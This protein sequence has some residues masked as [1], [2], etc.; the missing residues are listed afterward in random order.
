MFGL[1]CIYIETGS[2]TILHSNAV[3]VKFINLY[4]FD[5]QY[6]VTTYG[7]SLHNDKL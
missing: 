5:I 1:F 6:F 3:N 4:I 2:G 7:K